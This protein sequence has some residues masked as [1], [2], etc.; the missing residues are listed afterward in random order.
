MVAPERHDPET[1]ATVAK[2]LA[3]LI[4][5]PGDDLFRFRRGQAATEWMAEGEFLWAAQRLT[6]TDGVVVESTV[7]PGARPAGVNPDCP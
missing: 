3:N 1:L 5:V 4:P 2:L 6:E 7:V